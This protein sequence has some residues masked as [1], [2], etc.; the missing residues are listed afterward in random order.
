MTL[1]TD[2][3]ECE[4]ETAAPVATVW[5]AL[6]Q[7]ALISTWFS[8]S[9]DVKIEPG[10]EG[11]LTF[12]DGPESTTAVRVRIERVEPQRLLTFSWDYP[13]GAEPDETNASRVEFAVEE[14]G[15]GA[16]RVT[17]VENGLERL[18]RTEADKQAYFERHLAGWGFFLE[19]LRQQTTSIATR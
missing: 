10:A 9:V 19:R 6:T 8:D 5:D 17:V 7:P 16:T 11:T 14:T 1:I 12:V 4:I 3:I 2:R 13:D 18:A 15:E